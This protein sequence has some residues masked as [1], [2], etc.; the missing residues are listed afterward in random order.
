MPNICDTVLEVLIRYLGS[1]ATGV[2]RTEYGWKGLGSVG[3]GNL[4]GEAISESNI[5][6]SI[7]NKLCK[8]IH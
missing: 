8:V 5:G 3:V 6:E 1:T 7:S 2:D 4:F